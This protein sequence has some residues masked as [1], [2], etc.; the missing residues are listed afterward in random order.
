MGSSSTLLILFLPPL[1]GQICATLG[2]ALG[3]TLG[4]SLG[5]TLGAKHLEWRLVAVVGR[6]RPAGNGN[7][8]IGYLPPA[9]SSPASTKI[10]K[11]YLG[12]KERSLQI[13]KGNSE[14]SPM[15]PPGYNSSVTMNVRPQ[16]H[17]LLSIGKVRC[18]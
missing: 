11:E 7:R 15:F 14:E 9:V 16:D 3:E 2:A 17:L 8:P 4:L 13:H 1:P 12:A 5:T 6:R 18:S 10:G